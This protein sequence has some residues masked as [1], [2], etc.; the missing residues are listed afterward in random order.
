VDGRGHAE[1]G[2]SGEGGEEA[3]G[4]EAARKVL[5]PVKALVAIFLGLS[6]LQIVPLPR[7]IVEVLSPRIVE[8][9]GGGAWAASPGSPGS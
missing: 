3:A 6:V 4:G 9:K 2:R 8:I 1:G 5:W 7:G